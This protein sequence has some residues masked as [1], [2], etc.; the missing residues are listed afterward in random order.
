LADR[1]GD[2]WMAEP[3]G[4]AE[5]ARGEVGD[6]AARRVDDVRALAARDGKRIEPALLR[7]RE[8]RVGEAQANDV[9]RVQAGLPSLALAAIVPSSTAAPG[10]PAAPAPL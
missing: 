7:P 6:P 2:A 8:E 9:T 3:G 10:R 5:W 4:G 1:L